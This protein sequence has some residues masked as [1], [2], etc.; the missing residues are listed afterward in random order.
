K[1]LSISEDELHLYKIGV[2]N[3]LDKPIKNYFINNMALNRYFYS[4]TEDDLNV[5]RLEVL[6]SNLSDIK[7]YLEDFLTI[8]PNNNICT[9]GSKDDITT[10]LHLFNSIEKVD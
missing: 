3:Q 5:R 9:I 2:I 4:T 6:D 10:N 1:D 7:R 8:L